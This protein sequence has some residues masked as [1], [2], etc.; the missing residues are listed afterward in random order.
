MRLC[1]IVATTEYYTYGLACHAIEVRSHALGTIIAVFIENSVNCSSRKVIYD[2]L[3]EN[4]WRSQKSEK[5][6]NNDI[7]KCTL[8]L[9][10]NL[11]L[12]T[13]SN[14]IYAE[15]SDLIIYILQ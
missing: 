10:D 11:H 3:E 13:T 8:Y 14:D 4:N 2:W 5:Q 12:I 9:K 15:R 7:S 1:L 6:H